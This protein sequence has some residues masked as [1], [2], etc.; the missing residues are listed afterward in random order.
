MKARVRPGRLLFALATAAGCGNVAVLDE[1]AG[2]GGSGDGATAAGSGGAGGSGSSASASSAAGTSAAGG[3]STCE[4]NAPLCAESCGSDHFPEQGECK[5]GEWVCPPGTVNPDDCPGTTCWGA[6]LPCEHCGD[7][8]WMCIP[9]VACV[10]SC[11]GPLCAVCPDDPSAAQVGG[12]TCQC[13]AAG[14][15]ECALT[16][17]CCNADAD[18][19]A[20]PG[21]VCV[22]HVC[23]APVLD[24]CWR[25]DQCP[26]G[27]S[28][29]GASVCP[30]HA[31]CGTDD[32]PGFCATGA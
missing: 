19:A 15:F 16:P 5:G 31:D 17:G 18:C 14:L 30:C 32:Q 7:E 24:T 22:A 9:D 20:V 8:G 10:G 25:D 6:P 11:G 21:G 27:E 3:G 29:H 4:G 23:K 28:C 26:A 12:C 1:S 2:D 13:T